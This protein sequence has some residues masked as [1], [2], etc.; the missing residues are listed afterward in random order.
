M[1]GFFQNSFILRGGQSGKKLFTKVPNSWDDKSEALAFSFL[2]CGLLS[3]VY[4]VMSES[5]WFQ[6]MEK[7]VIIMRKGEGPFY[8]KITCTMSVIRVHN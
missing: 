8:L 7:G 6:P 3:E 1:Y 4:G 2:P 5:Q